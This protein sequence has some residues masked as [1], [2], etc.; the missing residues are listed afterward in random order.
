MHTFHFP[1][2]NQVCGLATEFQVWLSTTMIYRGRYIR[3]LG[4]AY[5][6]TLKV[7]VTNTNASK[8]EEQPKD[9]PGRIFEEYSRNIS[10]HCYCCYICYSCYNTVDRL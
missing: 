5:L 3:L 4:N 8:N 9:F 10:H 1:V 7:G 6:V 2:K